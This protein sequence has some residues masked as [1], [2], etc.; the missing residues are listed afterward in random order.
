MFIKMTAPP[1]MMIMMTAV[2][3]DIVTAESDI[4]NKKVCQQTRPQPGAGTFR[5]MVA[6]LRYVSITVLLLYVSE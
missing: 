6:V 1:I 3:T 5:V 4:H 2:I